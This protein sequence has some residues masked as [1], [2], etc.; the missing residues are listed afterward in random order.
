MIKP[1]SYWFRVTFGTGFRI[2][3]MGL[4]GLQETGLRIPLIGLYGFRATPGFLFPAHP[5]LVPVFRYFDFSIYIFVDF[6]YLGRT[7]LWCH[8]GWCFVT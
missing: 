1:F 5:I 8:I 3:L 7:V 6:K 4:S 2:P